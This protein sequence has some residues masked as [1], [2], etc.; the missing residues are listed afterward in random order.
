ME[1]TE[2]RYYF[3]IVVTGK[4]FHTELIRPTEVAKIITSVEQMIRAI[5]ARDN[6]D[7]DLR[8]DELVIGLSSV[9]QSELKNTFVTPYEN[10][11]SRAV[12]LTASA[13]NE[14]NFAAI[15]VE[16]IRAIKAL[17]AFNKL[18]D[19]STE[20]RQGNGTYARLAELKPNTRI[21][22]QTSII[23]AQTSMYG[24]LSRI[25]GYDPPRAYIRFLDG[26]KLSCRVKDT[27]LAHEMAEHL[28]QTIGVRGVAH[29][30][31]RNMLLHDFRIEELLPY[32]QTSLS[33]AMTGLRERI[34]KYYDDMED[35][36]TY[37]AN[38][39]NDE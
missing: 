10:E 35:V 34:G 6:P 14:E 25:G 38:Q 30:D 36:S 39:R 9:T 37:I 1:S 8:E 23:K 16:S 11:V 3:E 20:L 21:R 32:T 12:E 4:D 24:T 26:T 28:Y 19:T 18:T 7:L 29:W 22:T 31:I 2:H 15:P 5:V 13:I 17:R 33:D 27:Q